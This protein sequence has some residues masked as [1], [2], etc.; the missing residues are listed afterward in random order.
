MKN[1]S[2]RI[3]IISLLVLV[4]FGALSIFNNIPFLKSSNSQYLLSGY[5]A[6][7]SSVHS[8]KTQKPKNTPTA[9]KLPANTAASSNWAGYIASPVSNIGYT[10]VSGSWK[11]PN[12]SG[13]SKNEIAAQWVGLGGVTSKDLLQMGTIEQI[14]NGQ[15][16][17]MVFWEKL[18]DSA[19]TVATVPIGS[20]IDVNISKS[21]NLTWNL[22]FTASL[23]DGQVKTKTITTTLDSSYAEGI[24]TSAEWISEDP[25]SQ[26]GQL[27]PLADM[28]T[29][30][31]Q[32][33]K[34]DNEPLNAS[35]N[36]VQP[37]ALVSKNNSVLIYPSEIGSDGQS[38]TTT[39]IDS[40]PMNR[41]RN[42][43]KPFWRYNRRS[44]G[45]S[46]R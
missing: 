8:L 33:A 35:G 21:S 9:V 41:E 2:K 43:P 1:A 10:S 15:A 32:S 5:S 39:S 30:K 37:V 14:K 4:L 17:A 42:L 29:V 18:P 20:A 26:K 11:V 6:T 19:E 40:T 46:L 13:G 22:T 24:G 27:L 16:V 31:Y 25:S 28:G 45:F 34:V 36:K 38:F 7:E 12:I 3:K 44:F 23:P